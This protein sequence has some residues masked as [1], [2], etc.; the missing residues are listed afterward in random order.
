M[1]IEE[2]T[3]RD[4]L[5]KLKML[6]DISLE[7]A[8]QIYSVM[9]SFLQAIRDVSSQKST[10]DV[11]KIY[12]LLDKEYPIAALQDW[13]RTV[14]RQISMGQK[15]NFIF[16][17]SLEHGDPRL[18]EYWALVMKALEK[19]GSFEDRIISIRAVPKM[20]NS[21]PRYFQNL[22]KWEESEKM[23]I[24]KGER[25]GFFYYPRRDPE[26]GKDFTIAQI[27]QKLFLF[28]AVISSEECSM[29]D[30]AERASKY[31]KQN[32]LYVKLH[33]KKPPDKENVFYFNAK[34]V[35][36]ARTAGTIYALEY[37]KQNA[38]YIEVYTMAPYG[39]ETIIYTNTEGISM[40]K[41]VFEITMEE[42]LEN[43]IKQNI[44]SKDTAEEF[45]KHGGY[46]DHFPD[47]E[48]TKASVEYI[49]KRMKRKKEWK[50]MQ[51][52]VE[53]EDSWLEVIR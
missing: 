46:I 47:E 8:E 21:L 25:V 12:S 26:G 34:D 31:L 13:R 22:F 10:F 41:K 1:V 35:S 42:L 23:Y 19:H 4:L 20:Y 44:I 28:S 15:G 32:A 52:I 14:A 39:K 3:I 5:W 43:A 40:T 37:L 36:M 11:S 18:Y 6:G 45:L 27:F 48:F 7:E 49:G 50:A 24:L 29:F 53:E 2:K 17:M 30:V 9:R 38:P 16:S 51:K 33:V